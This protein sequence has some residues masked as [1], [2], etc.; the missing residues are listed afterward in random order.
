MVVRLQ[1]VT[2]VITRVILFLNNIKN[3]TTYNIFIIK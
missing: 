1:S 2:L 3:Y